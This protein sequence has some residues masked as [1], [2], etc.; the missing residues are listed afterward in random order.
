MKIT[1]L[2][3]EADDI[4]FSFRLLS[5]AKIDPAH[6]RLLVS[7]CDS[8]VRTHRLHNTRRLAQQTSL[9]WICEQSLW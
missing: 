2:R 4:H 9:L 5:S 6:M 1:L 8:P 7:H 3:R